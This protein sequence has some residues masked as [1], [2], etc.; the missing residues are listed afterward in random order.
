MVEERETAFMGRY[1]FRSNAIPAE[2]FLTTGRLDE[3]AVSVGIHWETFTPFYG[4]C[5][6]VS[7]KTGPE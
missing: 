2:N 1:G 7:G 3:L 4:V 6:G 5:Y